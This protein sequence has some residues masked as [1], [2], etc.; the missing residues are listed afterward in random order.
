MRVWGTVQRPS[1][2]WMGM[3]RRLMLFWTAEKDQGAKGA[4]NVDERGRLKKK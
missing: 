3:A 2:A 4:E 1:M